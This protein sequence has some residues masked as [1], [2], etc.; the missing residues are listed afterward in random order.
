M[1]AQSL[2]QTSPRIERDI[3][4]AQELDVSAN[5]SLTQPCVCWRSRAWTMHGSGRLT[6]PFARREPRR[7]LV[8]AVGTSVTF[9]SEAIHCGWLNAATVV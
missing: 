6:W 3:A 5:L 7:Y 2:E 1:T 9:R 8:V 4:H